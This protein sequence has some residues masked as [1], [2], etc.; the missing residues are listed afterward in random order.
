M[1]AILFFCYSRQNDEKIY[2]EN[3]KK[4]QEWRKIDGENG[5]KG[6]YYFVIFATFAT[7]AR[8]LMA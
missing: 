1:A 7:M 2:G 5:K 6:E 8:K 4:R 3:G